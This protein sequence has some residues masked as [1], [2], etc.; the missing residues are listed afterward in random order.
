MLDGLQGEVLHAIPGRVRLRVRGLKGDAVG[1][2]RLER[3]VASMPGVKV[4]AANAK[5][6]TL[7]LQYDPRIMT[8][9]PFGTVRRLRMGRNVP[10]A[11]PS[12]SEVADSVTNVFDGLDANI[13]RVS[14]GFINLR[15]LI[16]LTLLSLAV[17]R[18]II[19]GNVE[20]VPVQGLLWYSYSTFHNMHLQLQMKERLSNRKGGTP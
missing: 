13:E 20:A 12:G 8:G 3:E 17:K 11:A 1:A 16:P 6:G 7:L 19:D 15:T 14:G 2:R 9:E 4:A 18:I 5:T 10:H